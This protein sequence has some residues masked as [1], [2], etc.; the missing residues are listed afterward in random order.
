[1][2][3]R[4]GFSNSWVCEA[5]GW[6]QRKEDQ[7]ERSVHR[8]RNYNSQEVSRGRRGRGYPGAGPV[9][10]RVWRARAARMAGPVKD[11]EALQRLSFLYQVSPRRTHG[12]EPNVEGPQ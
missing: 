2:Q 9:D 8:S 1:M 6:R 3:G 7:K 11:R 5:I 12:G 10:G 4:G